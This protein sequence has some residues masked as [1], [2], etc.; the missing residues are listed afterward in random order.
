MLYVIIILLFVITISLFTRLV[1]LKK[2]IKKISKQLQ[3][4]NKQETSKKIELALFDQDLENLGQEINKL[5]DLS[6][7]EHRKR[8]N[9]ELENK[10]VIANMSHDLRTPLTSIQGYIQMAEKADMTYAERKELLAIANNRAKRLEALLKDFFELSVI[11]SNDYHLTFKRLNLNHIT[12]D[13]LMSFYDRFHEKN[14]EPT[15]DI[16]EKEIFITADESAVIRVLE[17]LL[18]NAITHSDG[19]IIIRLEEKNQVAKLI[20]QNNA[21]RLTEQDVRHLFDRFYMADQSRSRRSTGLG[22]SIVKSLMEKMNGR[23]SRHLDNGQL[24]IVCEWDTMK[25]ESM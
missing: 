18:S 19:N 22:L 20:V 16:P 2:E 7:A 14:L 6:V 24:S 17:N 11:E 5:I 3:S 15:I 13:V 4:Y 9:V 21:H 12:V 8:V 1:A 23:I 10:Q 25:Q